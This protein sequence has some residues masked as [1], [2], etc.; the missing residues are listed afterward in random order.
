MHVSVQILEQ[1]RKMW[2]DNKFTEYPIMKI[3][4]IVYKYI[5]HM[6]Y[7]RQKENDDNNL[8]M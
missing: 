1:D 4:L 6:I 7:S 3:K 5:E 2:T 8:R